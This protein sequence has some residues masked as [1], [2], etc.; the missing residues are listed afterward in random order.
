MT[1]TTDDVV[2]TR[3]DPFVRYGT[4]L[5]VVLLGYIL[6][7]RAF[8]YLHPP[9]IPLYVGEVLL[10]LGAWAAARSTGVLVRSVTAEPVLALLLG[11]VLWGAVRTPTGIVAHGLDAVRDAALWYYALFAFLAVAA[12]AVRPELPGLMADRL[13]RWAPLV[14]AG[15]AVSI[16]LQPFADSA[17]TVPF[18]DVSVLSHKAGGLAAGVLLVL[19]VLW[20]VPGQEKRR[21]RVPVSVFALVVIAL[22]AT[23]NRGALVGFTAG[24]AVALVFMVDRLRVLVWTVTIVGTTLAL[25]LLLSVKLPFPGLQ[26]REY[27]AAQLVTNVASLADVRTS[28]NLGGTVTGRTELWTRVLDKQVSERRVLVGAGF[29]PNLA[30]EVNV[31]DEGEDSLRNAHNS[32]L[33]V[34]ARM[35]AVGMLLWGAFWAAWYWRMAAACR[36]L[37]HTARHADAQ[38]GAVT[39]AVTT[40]VLVAAVFDP[41][42]EGPQ[43]AVLV[44]TLVGMGLAVTGRRR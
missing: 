26:G 44:W 37:R 3:T 7:D 15:L 42:L 43:L 8:A 18:T 34:L 25:L 40:A 29:G 38:L 36:R 41:Q 13:G 16:V 11:F 19:A 27:S 1:V 24:A 23:Q 32:H 2:V 12:V 39:L 9:G 21:A 33:S 22:V 28:G 31:L 17:P 14:L 10:L 5:G 20:L 30:A 4:V 35:G 6:F